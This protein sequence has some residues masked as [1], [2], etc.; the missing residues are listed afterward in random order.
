MNRFIV[1]A[2]KNK[3]LTILALLFVGMILFS[4]VKNYIETPHDLGPEL[5]YIGT[6]RTGCPL[7]GPL[8]A[9]L[10]CSQESGKRYY[11]ATKLSKDELVKYFTKAI[12]NEEVTLGGV[13][14]AKWTAE[15]IPFKLNNDSDR[16]FVITYYH[17]THAILEEN[18]LK[19]NKSFIISINKESYSAAKAAL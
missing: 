7:P 17:D 11:F 10:L 8:G 19:T 6:E 18:D 16:H 13:T 5:E 9:L 14:S 2:K 3:F 1:F 4:V 12:Y 15:Y